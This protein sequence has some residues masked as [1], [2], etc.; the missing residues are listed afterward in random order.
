[1]AATL[2]LPPGW[3][4]MT[5][6]NSPSPA[7]RGRWAWFDLGAQIIWLY[8]RWWAAPLWW[9]IRR[10]ALRHETGHAWGIPAAGC[11]GGHRWCVMAEESLVGY[12]DGSWKGKLKLLWFQ[13][14][15]RRGRGRFC[16]ECEKFIQDQ[17]KQAGV[18]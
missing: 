2:P 10:Y 1:M 9:L 8:P 16:P 4:V 12:L 5:A 15:D 13:L 7:A 17:L 11:P 6:W 3:K 18:A 14:T